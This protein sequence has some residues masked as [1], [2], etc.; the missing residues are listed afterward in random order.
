MSM[1][2]KCAHPDCTEDGIVPVEDDKW[3]CT[4]HINERVNSP[5]PSVDLVQCAYERHCARF[6]WSLSVSDPKRTL[7]KD[8]LSATR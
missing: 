4:A 5:A 3:L 8:L 6:E 1:R 2:H 7:R